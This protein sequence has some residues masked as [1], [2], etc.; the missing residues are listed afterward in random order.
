MRPPRRSS[1]GQRLMRWVFALMAVL[2][3]ASLL[4]QTCAPTGPVI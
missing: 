4:L 3:I 1:T 2:L